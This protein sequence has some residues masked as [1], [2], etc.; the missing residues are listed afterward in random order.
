MENK[1]K[2]KNKYSLSTKLIKIKLSEA[3]LLLLKIKPFSKIS[4]K[5][6]CKKSK[7]DHMVAFSVVKE[8]KDILFIINDY[9]DYEAFKKIR[10]VKS[11]NTHDK[12]LE[13]LM[14]RFDVFNRHRSAVIK[15][16]NYI[17]KKPDLIIF[18]IPLIIKSLTTILESSEVA[19]NGVLGN[20][21][22]EGLLII[23]ISIFL[24]WKKDETPGLDKTMAALNNHLNKAEYFVNLFNNK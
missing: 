12:I 18:F 10:K 15:I 14:I 5:D 2:K 17:A 8:K 21:K 24:I 20:L 7:I 19:S 23:Y 3:A 6:I 11:S 9:F 4:I 16:F 1:K 22:V 13:S